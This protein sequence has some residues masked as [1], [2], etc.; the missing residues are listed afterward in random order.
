MHPKQLARVQRKRAEKRDQ[1]AQ[2]QVRV[3]RAPTPGE[4]AQLDARLAVEEQ[5]LVRLDEQ[6]KLDAI[7]ENA[8]LFMDKIQAW[9]WLWRA[10]CV[11]R[12]QKRKG[13]SHLHPTTDKG[14]YQRTSTLLGLPKLPPMQELFHDKVPVVVKRVKSLPQKGNVPII[15]PEGFREV[16]PDAAEFWLHSRGFDFPKTQDMID[17]AE[18]VI[19]LVSTGELP[20]NVRWMERLYGAPDSTLAVTSGITP[21][22]S[23]PMRRTV[24]H[25][26]AGRVRVS[27]VPKRFGKRARRA[28]L[29]ECARIMRE[30]YN[31]AVV[32]T[33]GPFHQ[34]QKLVLRAFAYENAANRNR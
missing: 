27:A 2:E 28:A 14:N 22:A 3:G 32:R 33:R 4:L 31:E 13:Y 25:L 1:R 10:E 23:I 20:G 16:S 29:G 8:L 26:S 18:R 19:E 5:R 6:A 24:R 21:G 17:W 11:I 30:L 12:A 34:D 7:F 15:K 9:H